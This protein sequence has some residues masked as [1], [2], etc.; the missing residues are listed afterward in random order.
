MKCG[1]DFKSNLTNGSRN[2]LGVHGRQAT[3]FLS[4]L[5]IYK[6]S[7][8]VVSLHFQHFY[9]REKKVSTKSSPTTA[10]YP[11]KAGKCL[12]NSSLRLFK[13]FFF[14]HFC[15][16][17]N[18]KRLRDFFQRLRTTGG[19]REKRTAVVSQNRDEKSAR[20]KVQTKSLKS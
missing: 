5:V 1:V 19:K 10:P 17:F 3:R 4:R 6:K 14:A 12:L 20:K 11:N 8:L 2:V 9:P 15:I 18:E 7:F 13:F 16:F